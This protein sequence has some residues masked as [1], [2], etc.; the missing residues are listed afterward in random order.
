MVGRRVAR[1][2]VGDPD[3]RQFD[4]QRRRTEQPRDL[5]LGGDLVG[6]EVKKTNAQR[7]YVLAQRVRTAHHDDALVGERVTRGQFVG[8]GDRHGASLPVL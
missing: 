1:D 4:L 3:Q 6:H 5:R 2:M 7:T 8:N